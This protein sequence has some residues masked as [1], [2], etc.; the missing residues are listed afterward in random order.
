[1]ISTLSGFGALK[2]AHPKKLVGQHLH[3][4]MQFRLHYYLSLYMYV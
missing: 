2:V 1:M 3:E 4:K